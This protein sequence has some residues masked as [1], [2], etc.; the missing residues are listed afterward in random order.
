MRRTQYRLQHG[1]G[2]AGRRDGA[3]GRGAGAGDRRHRPRA[4]GACPPRAAR[5]GQPPFRAAGIV[6][7]AALPAGPGGGGGHGVIPT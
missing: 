5:A 6:L 1:G 7:N 3:C 4:P 2:S